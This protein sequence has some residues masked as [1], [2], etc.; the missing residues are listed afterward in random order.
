MIPPSIFNSKNSFR[1]LVGFICGW[2]LLN[3]LQAFFTGIYPDEA[4]YWIYSLNLQWGYFDH[5]PIVALGIKLGELFGHSSLY[6]RFG[7]ILFSAGSILFLYKATPRH[8]LGIGTFLLVFAS[9]IPFHV[10]GFIATPDGALFFFTAMFFYAYK[11]YLK[12]DVFINS[13]VVTISI[14][15]M[16]YS[17]YH[18]VL[19]LA[20]VFISNPRLIFRQSAWLIVLTVIIALAPH[21]YWQYLHGWPTIQYHL[22]DR[23]G[24]SY[25]VSKTIYYLLGQLLL[26]GPL[27]TIPAFYG[28]LKLR[29]SD[30]YLKAHCYTF[31]GVL[32]FFFLNTFRTG[33]EI[34][35]TLVGGV[36]FV[37]LLQSVLQKASPVF[38][39]VFMKLAILNIFLIA[40][41][42][43]FLVIPGSPLSKVNN[44][45]PMFYGKD[46]SDS[47][48][49][50]ATTTPVVFID[51]YAL[52]SLYKFYNPQVLTLSYNTINYRTNQFTISNEELLINNKKV[53]VQPGQKIDSADVFITSKYKNIF[54]HLVDSFKSVNALKIDWKN[55]IESGRAREEKLALLAVRNTSGESIIAGRHPFSIKYT[56]FRTRKVKLTSYG[57]F[58]KVKQ[59]APAQEEKLN[60]ILKLPKQKGNYRLVFSIVNHPL[61]GTLASDYYDIEVR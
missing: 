50:Y 44:L 20:F 58:L 30:L 60:L 7:T 40:I 54:L 21:I 26:W 8:F 39:A 13:V 17:K 2:I 34:H 52:P 23:I 24:S 12:R 35:W 27:I 57:Y 6:T 5:P 29:T 33:I 46:F 38:K 25:R 3:I 15:G 49:K 19:P 16:L 28:L 55:A 45:Q 9:V 22:T 1:I 53:F 56:F 14:I 42:R 47:V 51:N 37:V 48:Y 36:S 43:A 11:R 59:F 32:L 41:L 31:C 10:Y 61:E 18:A 4:Y